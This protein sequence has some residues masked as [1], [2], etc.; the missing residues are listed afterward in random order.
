MKGKD[1]SEN[2]VLL[3]VEDYFDMLRSEL[4]GEPFNK[5]EHRA[6]LVARLDERSEGSVEMKHA[7]ISA[8]LRDMG[9]PF[10]DGYK[11]R[12]NYQALV[13]D[14]IERVLPTDLKELIEKTLDSLPQPTLAPEMAGPDREVPPPTGDEIDRV[15]DRA[16][17]SRPVLRFDYVERDAR[18]RLL[19]ELGEEFVLEVERRRLREAGRQDLAHAV[20][21]TAKEMGDGAGYDIR[22]FTKEGNAVF[23]EVKTTNLGHRFP[24][25]VTSGEVKT[26]VKLEAQYRLVRVFN[27][28]KD[29]RFY[30]LRGAVSR[31]CLLAPELYR[32]RPV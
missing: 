7:N 18:N 12:Q 22:S 8:A 25:L 29:A 28:S 6:Q 32:A 14:V 26:S 9:L 24:F 10:I 13:L 3:A 31:T 5:T 19:G 16:G 1:W 15:E 4:R 27:F 21:W 30:T 23:V 11:P 2:E 20:Q 17:P